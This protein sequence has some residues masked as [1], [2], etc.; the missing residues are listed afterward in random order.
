M[1]TLKSQNNTSLMMVHFVQPK[2]T[3]WCPSLDL[4]HE[5]LF[6]MTILYNLGG[7]CA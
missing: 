1:L 4:L 6:L 5:G 2:N 7:I 3:I